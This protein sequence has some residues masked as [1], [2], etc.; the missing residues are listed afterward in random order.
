VLCPA[1]YDATT[2]PAVPPSVAYVTM[3]Q[4]LS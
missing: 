2:V 3:F 1:E 4:S